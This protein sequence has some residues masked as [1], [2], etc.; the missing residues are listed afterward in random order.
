MRRFVISVIAAVA[1]VLA[2]GG[3][4]LAGS[5]GGSSVTQAR[6][7]RALPA[8]FANLYAQQ[9]A[10]LGHRGVTPESLHAQAMCDKGGAVEANVGPGSNWNCLMSWTD[11]NTPMPPEGYGKFE[12]DVHSNGCFTAGGPSKLVGF[13]TITDVRGREVTNP[14]YEFDGCFDPEGDNTPTGVEFP[15][16]LNVTTTALRPD[17]DNRVSLQLSCGTGSAGCQGT[18]T[19]TAG[20]S[21]LGSVPFDLLEEQTGTVKLPTPV[22]SGAKEVTFTVTTTAGVGPSSSPTLP[23]PGQE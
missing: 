22:P 15:S 17:A 23:M 16:L 18:V 2:I 6:L 10:R 9:A 1:V 13:Q 4:V 3:A 21:K 5:G 14:V 20:D 19:A 12:L 7:E 8:E 11:P